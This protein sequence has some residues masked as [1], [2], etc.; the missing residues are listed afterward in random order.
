MPRSV[1]I[2]VT[3]LSLVVVVPVSTSTPSASTVTVPTAAGATAT[4]NWTG[5]AAPGT[6]VTS[7]CFPGG[8]PLVDEHAVTITVAPGTYNSVSARFTFNIAWTPASGDTTTSDLI[9]TLI[10]PNGLEIDS[11]DG[12]SP[13]ETI[14]ADNLAAGTYRVAVCGFLST[15]PQPYTGS[16]TVTT[17]AV[18]APP[19]NILRAA[20]KK[21][22]TPVKVTPENGY[23]YEPTLIVDQHGNAFSTAHKENWQLA[24]SPDPNSPTATR[25]MSWMWMS[26]D[27]GEHWINPPGLSPA[28]LEQRQAGAEGDLAMDDAGHV[29][30]VD[31]YLADVTMTRW[32]TKGLGQVLF[33]FT[34]PI[35]GTPEVDD[36]P[37][38]TAHGNGHVFYFSNTGNKS[39]NGGRY[40]S[41][42]SY[43]GGLTWD[44]VGVGLRDSGWCRPATD[45]RPGSTLVYAFCTNDNGK[46]YSY[47]STDDGRGYTRYEVGTYNDADV[48]QS[49]PSLQVAPDGTLWGLYVDS[50]NV[51][52][53]G[54]PITNQ[55]YLF[56]STD[57]GKT[58]TK[59]EITPVVGRYE[60]AWLAISADGKKLGMGIYYR[61]N[62][63]YPW[64]I[65]GVTWPVGGTPDAKQFVNLDPD[66][67]VA[68][69]EASRPP[70]DYLGSY[71]FPDGKLGVVWTRRVLWTDVTTIK[72]D[73]YFVRQR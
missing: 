70:G 5:T 6:F 34:L 60:Y 7:T 30:Y 73:I 13:S 51:G 46:L 32:T 3:V 12:G 49:Y 71:F 27:Q 39:Y 62:D 8:N 29:Y 72:R 28:S 41:H 19:E 16:L 56:K 23:G 44:S 64:S 18:T 31:T 17:S 40:T 35:V 38:I 67:P 52:D 45:H 2:L 63:K 65:A 10:G 9:L 68:P 42:A 47:V 55:I 14:I 21:W 59:T 22:G 66:N 4:D 20:G 11:S 37:W 43:D 33:D 69:V 24:L 26:I 58:F 54:I 53:G 36:R 15:A 61:P 48:T 25:S 1:S 57:Q 50:N